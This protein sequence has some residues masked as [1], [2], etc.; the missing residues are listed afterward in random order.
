[1]KE[2][3][4]DPQHKLYLTRRMSGTIHRAMLGKLARPSPDTRHQ[5]DAN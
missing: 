4:H 1:M 5:G 3:N 2:E